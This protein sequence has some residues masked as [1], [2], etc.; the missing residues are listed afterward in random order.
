MS[1]DAPEARSGDEAKPPSRH[2]LGQPAPHSGEPG[3]QAVANGV[4]TAP[5]R[6]VDMH[7][8]LDRM[9]N[10]AQ[11]A[12]DARERGMALFCTTITPDDARAAQARFT[13]HRHVRVGI[14][15]HPWW[16]ERG[17]HGE[18]AAERAAALAATSRYIGEIGL[19]FSCAHVQT[20]AEQLAAFE[21]ICQAC[22][23][24]A[25]PGRIMSIHAVRAAAEAL[26]I[27]ERYGLH[28]QA[29][30]IF[31]W[32]SGTSDDLARARRLGCRFSINERMLA[33]RRGR[34]YA[35]QM[36]LDRLLLETDAP[37]RLDTSGSAQAL[38]A[39]LARALA[40]LTRIRGIDAIELGTRIAHASLE[41]LGMPSGAAGGHASLP[42]IPQ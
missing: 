33:T 32:F 10:A 13:E 14:G 40:E 29:T 3:T 41:L 39:S 21:L 38:D 6:F 11:V 30:C 31:H 34:E 37:E 20:R 5:I 24:H 1:T 15:L 2:L 36:P 18:R 9:A 7:C 4:Q 22:A 16:V 8:H 23:S 27:L 42:H 17:T 12:R 35:R 19:D 28:A 26:D 25:I